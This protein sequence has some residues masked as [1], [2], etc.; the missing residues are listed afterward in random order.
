MQSGSLYEEEEDDDEDVRPFRP[1]FVQHSSILTKTAPFH[2]VTTASRIK[3]SS[4]GP[5][6]ELSDRSIDR[7]DIFIRLQSTAP[8][9]GRF[10]T[11]SYN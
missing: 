3:P 5:I 11:V 9:I 2:N 10:D 1:K 7:T 8:A 4:P 6:S